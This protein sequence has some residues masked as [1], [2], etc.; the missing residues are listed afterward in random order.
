M[1]TSV[2]NWVVVLFSGSEIVSLNITVTVFSIHLHMLA[3]IA[4]HRYD[5]I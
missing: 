2:N 5:H 3:S 4:S 1:D